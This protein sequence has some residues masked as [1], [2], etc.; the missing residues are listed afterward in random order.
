MAIE[1]QVVNAIFQVYVIIAETQKHGKTQIQT[2][3][4]RCWNNIMPG[5]RS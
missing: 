5:D 3:E 4:K 1:N 2:W